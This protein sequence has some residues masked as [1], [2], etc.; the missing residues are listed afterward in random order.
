MRAS[1]T[2]CSTS[3]TVRL[4]VISADRT[5]ASAPVR[6]AWACSTSV[7]VSRGS[8]RAIRSPR[9]TTDPSSTASRT[10]VPPALLRTVTVVRGTRLPVPL[11]ERNNSPFDTGA[12][13]NSTSAPPCVLLRTVYH[14]AAP[15]TTRAATTPTV[16]L[17]IPLLILRLAHPESDPRRQGPVGLRL[18]IGHTGFGQNLF[19]LSPK[20]PGR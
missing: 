19:P 3:W 12:Y 9:L 4:A 11:V 2:D 18:S 6:S 14:P 10:T 1:L 20:S 5:R 16:V 15:K 17:F 7:R 13:R 8:I